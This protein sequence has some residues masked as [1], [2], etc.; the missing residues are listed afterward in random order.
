[1][2]KL[3]L[4]ELG[5]EPLRRDGS[6]AL[7]GEPW[8]DTELSFVDPPRVEVTARETGDGGIHVTGRLWGT[9]EVACRRCLEPVRRSLEIE[10][11]WLFEPGLEE[12]AEDEGVFPLDDEE[13]GVLDLTPRIREEFLLEAPAYPLCSEDCQGLCPVCGT[14]QNESSCECDTSEV[15][16]RW[17]PLEDLASS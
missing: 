4:H 3:Q 9:V 6:M 16:P 17:G 5:R 11:D 15:D 14:N 1:M 8:T 10:V 13:D 2:V 12:D 7:E